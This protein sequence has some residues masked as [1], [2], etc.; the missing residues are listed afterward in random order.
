MTATLTELRELEREAARQWLDLLDRVDEMSRMR[1]DD[2]ASGCLKNFLAAQIRAQ[3]AGLRRL[4]LLIEI[5][6][7]EGSDAKECPDFSTA[8]DQHE[9]TPSRA[10]H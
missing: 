2:P 9:G 8:T 1:A 6:Q 10:E 3:E 7:L 4:E 5:S